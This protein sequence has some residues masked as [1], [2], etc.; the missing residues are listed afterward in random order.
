MNLG[1]LTWLYNKKP[2][3]K[4]VEWAGS[5]II[6]KGVD[7]GI[8]H[9]E[10]LQENF[11]VFLM[12]WL[13]LVQCGFIAK[14]KDMPKEKKATLILSEVYSVALGITG[15][16]LLKKPIRKLRDAFV[17]RASELY[18]NSKTENEIKSLTNGIK[19]AVP[20]AISTVLFQYVGQVLTAP[21][22]SKT[23]AYLNKQGKLDFL[24]TKKNKQN[25]PKK[26]LSV[27]A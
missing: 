20:A 13:S 11:P 9:Y 2:A 24:D 16:L 26:A 1:I 14:N 4:Y 12:A 6:K 17:N 5:N 21:F 7:T 3:Q 25:T 10:K 18:K 15:S 19:T 27:S 8:T 23:S 22:A